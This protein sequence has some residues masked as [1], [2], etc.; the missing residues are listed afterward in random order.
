MQKSG[1]YN[2][3]II[4]FRSPSYGFSTSTFNLQNKMVATQQKLQDQDNK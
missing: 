1:E 4:T 2:C 3:I